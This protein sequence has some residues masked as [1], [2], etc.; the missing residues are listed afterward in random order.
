MRGLIVVGK[1]AG[2]EREKREKKKR[3]SGGGK[4][5]YLWAGTHQRAPESTEGA[6]PS[7][8]GATAGIN[9]S[10]LSKSDL[11]LAALSVLESAP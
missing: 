3:K 5:I 7:W 11:A 10:A 9:P 6:K 8:G 2:W 4:R 1:I